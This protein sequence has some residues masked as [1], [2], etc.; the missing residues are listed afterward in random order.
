MN[1][2]NFL[3][4][5]EDSEESFKE[6][7]FQALLKSP[8]EE[9]R[10]WRTQ[11]KQEIDFVIDGRHGFSIKYDKTAFRSFRQKPFLRA[12]PHIPASLITYSDLEYLDIFDF[13]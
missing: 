6:A 7:F 4:D 13:V 12:Y 5:R 3:T 1:N 9:P 8:L 2:F 11:T 10:F